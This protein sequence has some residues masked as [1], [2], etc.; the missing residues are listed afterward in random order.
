MGF[1]PS[2]SQPCSKYNYINCNRYPICFSIF[3]FM[4]R[5]SL[6]LSLI[7]LSIILIMVFGQRVPAPRSILIDSIIT[8]S[9]RS[10]PVETSSPMVLDATGA[11]PVPYN[12][13]LVKHSYFYNSHVWQSSSVASSSASSL[14]SSDVFVLTNNHIHI[15][16]IPHSVWSSSSMRSASSSQFASHSGPAS[17]PGRSR[18]RPR[19]TINCENSTLPCSSSQPSK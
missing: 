7:G 2:T 16:P 5:S 14:A 17:V 12:Q 19:T 6:I 10:V 9:A 13:F 8:S 11:V 4:K 3:L 1:N 15:H 18:P